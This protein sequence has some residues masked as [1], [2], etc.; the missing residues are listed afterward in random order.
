MVAA[1]EVVEVVD[2]M[3]VI[4]AAAVTGAAAE[5]VIKK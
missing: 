4:M 5:G 2:Q 3:A 1:L